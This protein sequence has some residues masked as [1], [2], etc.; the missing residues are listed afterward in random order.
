MNHRNQTSPKKH[1]KSTRKITIIILLALN[2]A[3][4]WA[5]NNTSQTLRINSVSA[6]N[7]VFS[8]KIRSNTPSDNYTLIGVPTQV[9]YVIQRIN[10]F[11]AD[12]SSDKN[13]YVQFG[14]YNGVNS[15][16]FGS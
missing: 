16:W 7:H 12:M 5:M 11:I 15:H 8:L 4:T 1:M 3:T 2:T 9:S 13:A 6:S 14:Y 10:H